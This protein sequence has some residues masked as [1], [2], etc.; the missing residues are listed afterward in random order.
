MPVGGAFHEEKREFL[1][2]LTSNF[3][4]D[5]RKLIIST[6]SPFTELLNRVRFPVCDPDKDCCRNM[7]STSEENSKCP[8]YSTQLVF[9]EGL[10]D[11]PIPP[12]LKVEHLHLLYEAM[13]K[14]ME[15]YNPLSDSFS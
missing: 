14:A 13:L 8:N 11:L 2:M 3:Q 7:G 9:E 1:K 5:G 6:K 10:L 4:I 15:N 12:K